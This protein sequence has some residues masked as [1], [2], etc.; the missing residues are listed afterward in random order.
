[1]NLFDLFI[2]IGVDDQ[3]SNHI[4]GLTQKLGNGLKTASKIGTAAVAAAATGIAVLTKESIN[5]YAEYEQLVGGVDTL[6]KESSRKVQEY[7]ANAFKTAGLS[8]NEYMNTVTS[9]SASLLQSL[10]GDTEKA[11]EYAQQAITDMADNANKMG[12][13]ISMI[14]NA[15]Q[16]FAKKNYT[17][18]DNLK[19]GYGGTQQEM[20]R[21]MQDAEKLGAKFNSE[22]YLTEKGSLVADF[23]DITE[24][25]H[26]IQTEMGITGTTAK[27]ASETISGSVASMKSAW[28]NLLTGLADDTADYQT[29]IDNFV[30]SVE[31]VGG[32]ILPR[33]EIVLGGVAKLIEGLAPMIA[34]RLPAIIQS[35]LPGLLN[36]AINVVNAFS[37][38]LPG[39]I[40]SLVPVIAEAAPKIMLAGITLTKS[41][42][43]GLV[44][45][46]SNPDT[47]A[48]IIQAVA[49]MAKIFIERKVETAKAAIG[50]IMNIATSLVEHIGEMIP[51][52]MEF[53]SGIAAFIGENVGPMITSAISIIAKL[54]E[55]IISHIV[56]LIPVVLTVVQ[57]IA[58]FLIDNAGELLT[59]AISI[60]STLGGFIVENVTEMLPQIVNFV[61]GIAQYLM[62]PDVLVPLVESALE[63]VVSLATGIIQ[64]I[65]KILPAVLSIIKGISDFVMK[66]LPMVVEIGIRLLTALISDINT[67]IAEIV[68]VL[69]DIIEAVVATLIGSIPLIIDT[70]VK[71]L[72]SLVD[73]IDDIL[74]PI[75]RMLPKLISGIVSALLS[76]KN[77]KAIIDAGISL[78]STLL[79]DIPAITRSLLGSVGEVIRE[80]VRGFTSGDFIRQMIGV[81]RDLI[82]GIAEGIKNFDLFG[83]VKNSFDNL[84]GGVK[85][86]FGIKSP[87]RKFRDEIGKQLAAGIGV[88]FDVEMPSVTRLAVNDLGKMTNSLDT[89]MSTISIQHQGMSG[90]F[91][92]QVTVNINGA[93][94]IDART[95]AQEAAE[96]VSRALQNMTERRAA[97]YG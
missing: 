55:G 94:H 17:M 40:E 73:N 93:D 16:G 86:F 89:E 74:V 67:I 23:A 30:S 81:G 63:L 42:I 52:I 37:A 39:L 71:L 85:D 26:V 2:K 57:G 72:S 53:V 68:A 11:A 51:F 41:L 56:D 20:F 14:Q 48:S 10:E 44:K 3:A 47:I 12:T 60:I 50:V 29:L 92:P 35:V 61:L 5:N 45:A 96:A 91:A 34:E 6:F 84:V 70:G 7:A 82:S 27:E 49:E 54:G 28:S 9:F 24:A 1:M 46:I 88:G 18:L 77:I 32:N 15:Y 19:L 65:P 33:I 95:L 83:S 64:A 78:I 4:S 97:V 69:P 75:I 25:I 21:L 80:L 58:G 36:G 22:F 62:D 38:E 87:S 8:A 66:N 59:S 76:P 43:S 31:T 79:N 90:A 13:D